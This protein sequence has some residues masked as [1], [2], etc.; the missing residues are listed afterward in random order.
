MLEKMINRARSDGPSAAA[1]R[2]RDVGV[3][4]LEQRTAYPFDGEVTIRVTPERESTFKVY[5]RIPQWAARTSVAVN[6]ASI[7]GEAEAGAFID[8]YKIEETL[9]VPS[10]TD[11]S[12]LET[13]PA[14]DTAEGPDVHVAPL[15]R[16]A[17]VFSP[18][19]RAGGRRDRT[20]RL[21]WMPLAP[22]SQ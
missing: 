3:V 1:L 13:L 19:Y 4:S 18:Y 21:T 7:T 11:P 12:W 16:P 20:W 17:L 8:G 10:P 22:E 6:G 14:T 15:G 5:V 2:V 9:R